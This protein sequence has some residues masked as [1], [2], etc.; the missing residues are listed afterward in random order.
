M[1][2]VGERLD[3]E[4]D[5]WKGEMG[6]ERRE[7]GEY[8]RWTK[9]VIGVC[10]DRENGWMIISTVSISY[11]FFF[12]FLFFC[13]N[14]NSVTALQRHRKLILAFLFPFLPIS[15]DSHFFYTFPFSCYPLSSS[16]SLLLSPLLF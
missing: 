10:K 9:R 5:R 6:G 14:S 4:E 11:T 16:L 12:Y 7:M 8:F 2:E 15:I 13:V 3:G 1:K